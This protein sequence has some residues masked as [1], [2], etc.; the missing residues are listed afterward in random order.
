MKE[1]FDPVEMGKKPRVAVEMMAG[2]VHRLLVDRRRDDAIDLAGHGKF[3]GALDVAHG[4][5]S[6]HG[7]DLADLRQAAVDHDF[8]DRN[9]TSRRHCGKPQLRARHPVCPLQ[10]LDI[11]YDNEIDPVG[12]RQCR[13]RL[14]DDFRSDAGRIAECD[15]YA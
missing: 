2:E 14:D 3:D 7:T 11:A 5:V 13:Q 6:R 15:G 1:L 12:F 8:I 9:D 10:R 4:C